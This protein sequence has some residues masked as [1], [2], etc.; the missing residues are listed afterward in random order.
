VITLTVLCSWDFI[1]LLF[2][3]LQRPNSV[4]IPKRL[5]HQRSSQ[6]FAVSA[7]AWSL[8]SKGSTIVMC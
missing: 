6:S 5:A 3:A 4:R 2:S 1:Q 8:A 7:W